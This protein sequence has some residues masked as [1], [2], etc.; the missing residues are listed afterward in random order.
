MVKEAPDGPSALRGLRTKSLNSGI[1]PAFTA[2]NLRKPVV[3]QQV[4]GDSLVSR[5][6]FPPHMDTG[7]LCRRAARMVVS[8]SLRTAGW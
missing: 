7:T 5:R 2:G 6:P 3:K 1:A 8:M 4:R